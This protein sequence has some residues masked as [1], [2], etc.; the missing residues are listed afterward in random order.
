[1]DERV[2]GFVDEEVSIGDYVLT[3]GELTAL[4]VI[5]AVSRLIP[6][7]LGCEGAPEDDSFSQGLLE[8]PQYTRPRA[9][10]GV[11]VPDALLSGDHRAIEKWRRRE[12]L[13]RTWKR[14]PDLLAKANLSR[15]DLEILEELKGGRV[16]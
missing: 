16:D 9:F 15:E 5:D 4:V 14:R 3:G 11:R 1:M 10:E 13:R 7:V 6:G 8:Y 2:R 12:A